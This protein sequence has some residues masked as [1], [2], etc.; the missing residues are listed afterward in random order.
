MP[1]GTEKAI[2]FVPIILDF[3]PGGA[4]IGEAFVKPKPKNPA[5]AIFF[6]KKPSEVQVC[7]RPTDRL[8]IPFS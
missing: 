4:T 8:A 7:A 5:C 2:G 6:V 1:F 3:P